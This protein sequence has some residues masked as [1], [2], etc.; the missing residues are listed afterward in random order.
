LW[1]MWLKSDAIWGQESTKICLLIL[2]WKLCF[3]HYSIKSV[4][5]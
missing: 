5:K 3:I 4:Q 2:I 1:C